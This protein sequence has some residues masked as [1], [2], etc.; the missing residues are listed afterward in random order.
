M[1]KR[2]KCALCTSLFLTA[3]NIPLTSLA[4]TAFEDCHIASNEELDELRGGFEVNV[5]GTQ[6]KMA[7]S[8]ESVTFINGQLAAT[9]KLNVPDLSSLA[10][11]GAQVTYSRSA[12]GA[13]ALNTSQ[14]N[15]TQQQFNDLGKTVNV[16]QN[17]VGNVVNLPQNLNS[18]GTIL[19]NSLDNQV[20][21]N[22]TTLNVSIANQALARSTLMNEAINQGISRSIR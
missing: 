10:N 8:L 1:N 18:V 5:N 19:Q 20:I 21:R 7:F 9:T 14:T 16:I 13:S 22:V 6:L 4:E 17:G 11:G 2:M 3:F 15:L 12:S